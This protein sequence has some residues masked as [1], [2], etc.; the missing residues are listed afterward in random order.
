MKIGFT[1]TAEPI[2]VETAPVTQTPD[3]VANDHV[4]VVDDD[5]AFNS[6]VTVGLRRSAI[7]VSQCYDGDEAINAIDIF[8]PSLVLLDLDLPGTSGIDVVKRIRAA[9][10]TVPV[11]MMS[12]YDA[13][14]SRAEGSGLDVLRMVHKPLAVAGLARLVR[15]VL[16][17]PAAAAGK[18]RR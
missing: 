3:A 6:L 8:N 12:G 1:G 14:M 5:K 17:R 2:G 4:L 16:D 18:D 15:E 7:G 9:G 11:V 13:L 10:H